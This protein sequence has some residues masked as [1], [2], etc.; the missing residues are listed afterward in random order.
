MSIF[1]DAI[2]NA[3][4]GKLKKHLKD[5]KCKG[6]ICTLDENGELSI[7]EIGKDVV[8]LPIEDFNAMKKLI[9]NG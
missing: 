2:A 1:T 5:E 6:Y 7:K 8:V 4:L 3:A 9:Q